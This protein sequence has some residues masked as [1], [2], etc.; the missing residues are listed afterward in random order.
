MG[1]LKNI[2][3][4]IAL[5]SVQAFSCAGG[6]G[7]TYVK[8][9]YYNFLDPSFVDIDPKNP[10]YDLSEGYGAHSDR[11]DHFRND[12][13]PAHN[14]EAWSGYFG[15]KMTKEEINELFYDSAPIQEIYKKYQAKIDDANFD[16]YI[17]FLSLQMPFAI[18]NEGEKLPPNYNAIITE[19]IKLIS[20]TQD[21]FLKQRYLFLVMR[22]YHYY[23]EFSQE[24]KL[25]EEYKSVIIKGSI[26]D[27]WITALRAGAFERMDKMVEANML[28][29]KIFAT[30]KVNPYLGYYDFKV[31]SDTNWHAMLDR[32]V[33]EDEKAL[34]YFLRAMHWQNSGIKDLKSIAKIAPQSI[35]FDRL[36][37]MVM[38]DL[39][40]QRYTI[41]Q[42]EYYKIKTDEIKKSY[43]EQIAAY[44]DI[45]KAQ[46]DP[47]F[48]T[49]YANLYLDMIDY[50]PLDKKRF[51]QLRAKAS[52][53]EQVYVALIGYL[54]MLNRTKNLKN[55]AKLATAIKPIL[56]QLP[57]AQQQS[58]LRY[59]VL[60][61]AT[62][63]PQGHAKRD[64]LK[65]Y[66]ANGSSYYMPYY[67]GLW[68]LVN[69]NA[70]EFERYIKE[71]NRSFFEQK[72]YEYNMKN[73]QSGDIYKIAALLFMQD[74]DFKKANKYLAKLPKDSEASPYNP[75]NT[76]V[77]GNNRSGKKGEY[78]QKKFAKVM[79]DL[80]QKIKAGS[81]DP[82]D[83]YLYA[84]GLYNKSWFG[85]FPMS[86]TLHRSVYL[87]SSPYESLPKST[88]LSLAQKEYK[89]ALRYARKKE[90]KAKIAYQLLKIDLANACIAYVKS[91]AWGPSFGYL[92]EMKEV[93]QKDKNFSSN[94]IKYKREYSNTQYG[95][96]VIKSCASFRFF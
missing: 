11:W 85:S 88:D 3:M 4:G 16:T 62:L 90:F 29:A 43:A 35:W 47:S 14:I 95:K 15:S 86:A 59:S 50:K 23:G 6:W 64:I 94:I 25:Y 21:R 72:A 54:D 61:I 57:E 65:L 1:F 92:E 24:L 52:K 39:Q 13:E 83:H 51:K 28:Y 8:D 20:D 73:L 87:S 48:F 58:L 41:M 67:Y 9:E 18:K 2:V 53:K 19:G 27:E 84:T 5:L 80:Q 34:L 45:L 66:T 7:E 71:K 30:H 40:N 74:N 81:K 70:D 26:V 12:V 60:Q 31:T 56:S 38:Q 42:E 63:Y 36:S 17:N 96:E 22:L 89:I 46:K 76:F 44:K 79:L 55:Q 91:G 93:L 32:A 82:M 69:A 78:T 75:F 10:L 49:L 77:S 33:N 37:Y 68:S